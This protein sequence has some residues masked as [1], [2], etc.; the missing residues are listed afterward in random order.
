MDIDLITQAADYILA[1]TSLK[2]DIAVILGS[3]FGGFAAQVSGVRIPYQDIP[4]FPVSTAPTHSGVLHIGKL[5]GQN[6][7]AME[8]R[9]HMYEGYSPQEVIFPL[10]VMADLG[11]QNLIVTNAAGGINTGYKAGDIVFIKDHLS[12]PGLAG[13]GPTRGAHDA[14]L[15]SRF[16]PLNKAYSPQLLAFAQGQLKAMDEAFKT[17]T[18]GF[19]VGPSLETPAEVRALRA[20]GCDLV[21]MSSVPEVIAARQMGLEVLA[22][23]AVTNMAIDD[24]NNDSV[25]CAADVFKA[26]EDMSPKLHE[27]LNRLINYYPESA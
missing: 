21:G 26:M 4:G 7:I 2:P 15:G 9:L 14:A 6:I 23:S 12:L 10:R 8:G 22:F 1:Q 17:G 13:A 20:L 5:H 25:T 3:G 18:Y 24:I 19:V 11:A 27:V 16:T